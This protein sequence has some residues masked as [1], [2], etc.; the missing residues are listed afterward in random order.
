MTPP[1][2]TPSSIEA[3]D[4]DEPRDREL[5]H[6]VAD[7]RDRVGDEERIERSPPHPG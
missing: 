3:Q 2:T 6:D 1:S 4:E 5:S 7:E